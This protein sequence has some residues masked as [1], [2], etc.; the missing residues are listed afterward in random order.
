MK[1][2]EIYKMAIEVLEED[3]YDMQDDFSNEEI[4][5][6]V[7]KIVAGINNACTHIQRVDQRLGAFQIRVCNARANSGGSW[8]SMSSTDKTVVSRSLA[9]IIDIDKPC[10]DIDD[11]KTLIEMLNEA[12]FAIYN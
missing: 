3:W 10:C 9:H 7:Q 11:I 8:I 2:N 6:C 4:A 5:T 1:P 12:W